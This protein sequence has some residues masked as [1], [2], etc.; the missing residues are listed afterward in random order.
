M[1]IYCDK[2]EK[3]VE[4]GKGFFW[5]CGLITV[6]QEGVRKISTLNIRA[7]RPSQLNGRAGREKDER[8]DFHR[9][10][11]QL[12]G[13]NGMTSV[14]TSRKLTPQTSVIRNDIAGAFCSLWAR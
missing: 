10:H 2:L 3:E 11:V 5:G 14:G 7:R 9:V 8:P 12:F 13:A 1:Q 4:C 6:S